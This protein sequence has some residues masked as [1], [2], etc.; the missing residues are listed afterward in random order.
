MSGDILLLRLI[1][2]KAKRAFIAIK[3]AAAKRIVG[4]P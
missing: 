2:L 3:Q 1:D 4:V